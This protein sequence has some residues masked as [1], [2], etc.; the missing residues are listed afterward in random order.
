M[1]ASKAIRFRSP[2]AVG[3]VVF[4]VLIVMLAAVVFTGHTDTKD[5]FQFAAPIPFFAF[6]AHQG[7]SR[8][9]FSIRPLFLMEGIS[10]RVAGG[11]AALVAIL[12]AYFGFF[13]FV[14]WFYS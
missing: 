2:R 12:S 4:S 14:R 6:F 10:A 5:W 1:D 9:R 8:G 11:I 3:T 7:L 13:T